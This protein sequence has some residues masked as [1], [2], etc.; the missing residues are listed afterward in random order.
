MGSLVHIAVERRIVMLEW[1]GLIESEVEL[2]LSDFGV[3]LGH[4]EAM[5]VLLDMIREAQRENLEIQSLI[6]KVRSDSVPRFG[7]D[8]SEVL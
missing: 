5:P 2:Q 8:D 6:D 4:I 1:Q 3:L 7:V